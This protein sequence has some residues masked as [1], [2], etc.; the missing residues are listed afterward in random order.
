MYRY[1][2]KLR[3]ISLQ[4]F[5]NSSV[6]R[7]YVENYNIQISVSE[8]YFCRFYAS[9]VTTVVSTFKTRKGYNRPIVAC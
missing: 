6:R 1:L 2:T 3:V 7:G 4:I 5:K 9:C 8:F